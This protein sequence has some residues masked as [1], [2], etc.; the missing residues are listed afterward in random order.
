LQLPVLLQR[1]EQTDVC[2]GSGNWCPVFALSGF[3]LPQLQNATIKN[4]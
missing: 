3:H 2:K 4:I 1:Q